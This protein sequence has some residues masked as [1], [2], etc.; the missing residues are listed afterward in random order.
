MDLPA[1]EVLAEF[2]GPVFFG[3]GHED[4]TA[5]AAGLFEQGEEAAAAFDVEFAH[6]VV[7]EEDGRGAVDAGKEFG[8]GHF[9]GDGEGALLAFAAELGGGFF[10]LQ[11]LEV[12]AM[13]ADEGGAEAAFAGAG[14]GEFDGEIV[15]DAGQI[16]KAE[17]LGIVGNAAVGEAGEGGEFGD[18]FAAGADEVV[19]EFDEF[20]GEAVEGGFVGLALFE[21]GVA[22]A[23]AVQVALEEGQVAGLGLSEEEVEKAAAGAGGAFDE[24]EVLGAEDNGAE[25]AEVFHEAFDGLAVEGE[26]AFAAG[27][28]H[29]D[30]A[31]ALADDF[32]A[33]EVA[34]GAVPD[35]LGAADAAKGAEGGQEVDGFEDVGLTLGVV[36]EEDVESGREINVQPRVIA[37]VTETQMSQMHGVENG[38]WR[39]GARVFLKAKGERPPL[40][41]HAQPPREASGGRGQK[42]A[43][44][45]FMPGNGSLNMAHHKCLNLV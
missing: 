22:G 37:E 8:L 26:V 30:F 4:L 17:V 40:T 44:I 31:F 16:I 14:L 3:A 10:V 15:Y 20:R 33:D 1:V 7:D 34:F 25:G 24:L 12:V 38:V 36:A 5:A 28:V 23:D 18:E 42:N 21:D 35:H 2:A 9:E 39:G 41:G 27:P 29:F 13:G 6:D 32:A 19:A 11:E 45:C 43:T